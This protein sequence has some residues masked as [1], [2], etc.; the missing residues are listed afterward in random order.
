M[1]QIDLM[2]R[3]PIYEQIIEQ[4][5]RLI[6]TGLLQPL[7]RMPS[8]RSLSV[9]LSVNPNTIQRAYAELCSQ[10]VLCTAVGRGCFVAE[11]A[12][13]RVRSG[14]QRLLQ[15]VRELT[16]KLAIAEYPKNELIRLG[17]EVYRKEGT[18]QRD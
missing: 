11:D 10:S 18:K 15:E 16:E 6:L 7:E 9:E 17:G 12:P 1:I 2:S 8:V 5:R 3:V 13:E 4:I 14:A